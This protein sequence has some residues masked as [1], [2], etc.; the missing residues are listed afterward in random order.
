MTKSKILILVFLA[1]ATSAAFSI[2]AENKQDSDIFTGLRR[3]E[4]VTVTLKNDVSYTG[5]IKS[6]INDRIEVDISFD[7]PV[8]KGSFSFRARDIKS[9]VTRSNLSKVEKD[10]IAADKEKKESER[11]RELPGKTPS[12]EEP[13]EPANPTEKKEL[14]GDELL[15]LLDK[16][17]QG[18]KWNGKAYQAIADKSAF[19]RTSEETAFMEN[20]QD[21]L[22]A[23]E[24]KGKQGDM[25]FFRKYL[26][27]KG[28]G[29]EKYTELITKYI[30]LKVG[31]TA[32]EQEFVDKYEIWKKA[33]PI[34][35][36][37]QKKK[38]EEEK[39]ESKP[40]PESAPEEEPPAENPAGE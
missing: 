19:L 30:R 27:E 36:E 39:K 33:R 25:E 38:Q 15:G 7:D 18:E 32:E 10:K 40:A 3:G 22:K 5:A 1:L 2:R 23:I 11:A 31:L 37:E 26:P 35:E 21:W 34:Y 4:R 6:I 24:L 28:W 8:L 29:E 12:G 14:K 20:Y 13:V 16:F 9:I 17:P